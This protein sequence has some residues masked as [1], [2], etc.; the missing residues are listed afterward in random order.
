[1][2]FCHGL[3]TIFNLVKAHVFHR[4]AMVFLSFVQPS[5]VWDSEDFIIYFEGH[6]ETWEFNKDTQSV[7]CRGK[8]W[9]EETV[10]KT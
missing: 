9:G 1:M 5:E 3:I 2:V 6:W 7:R 8:K 10:T 4:K